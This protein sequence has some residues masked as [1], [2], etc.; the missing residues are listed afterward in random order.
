MAA[1]LSGINIKLGTQTAELEKGFKKAQGDVGDFGKKLEGVAKAVGIAALA[2]GTAVLAAG[3]AAVK[4]Q[5]PELDRIAKVSARLG[6]AGQSLLELSHAAKLAGA[7][8]EELIKALEFTQ[9]A[10]GEAI[11]GTGEAVDT[12]KLLKL[13]ATELA[14]MDP[15]DAFLKLGDAIDKLPTQAQKFSAASD[16]M[17]RGGKNLINLMMQGGAATREAMER[18]RELHGV[19]TE[20]DFQNV[21]DANDAM[22]DLMAAFAGVARVITVEV[23]PAIERFAKAVAPLVA[24]IGEM[25][26][27]TLRMVAGMVGFSI[28]L[29]GM[30]LLAPKIVKAIRTIV[31]ALRTMAVAEAFAQAMTGA[32]MI[33]LLASLAVAE[34]VGIGVMLMFDSMT[35]EMDKAQK[36]LEKTGK[37]MPDVAGK[38]KA[39]M[40]DITDSTAEAAKTMEVLRRE[41]DKLTESLRTPFESLA[42]DVARFNELLG[43]GAIT[44]E[45][46]GRAIDKVQKEFLDAEKAKIKF[47]EPAG[48]QNIAAV[49]R[50]S[51]A[52]F[53]A[54]VD[55]REE[56]RHQREYQAA[57]LRHMKLLE[58][59]QLDALK[60]LEKGGV[61]IRKVGL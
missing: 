10:L 37:N 8:Q 13:N 60:E 35:K 58:K 21:Q 44:M 25:K 15:I 61:I 38:V 20:A 11:G 59:I 40:A 23:A 45:T 52:G 33:T 2:M 34:A 16:L 12:L 17:S 30:L 4:S 14:E 48:P 24:R 42:A 7:S 50:A 39:A 43:A 46:Y 26:E 47:E 36:E 3:V 22:T 32:G 6:I 51:M 54:V 29:G 41:G 49:T 55:A 19:I 5:L 31:V 1:Q 9:K 27:G 28:A 57:H 56:Q 18:F 53:S